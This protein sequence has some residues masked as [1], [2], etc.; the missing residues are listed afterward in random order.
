[1]RSLW[2]AAGGGG[3]LCFVKFSEAVEIHIWIDAFAGEKV[4]I[5]CIWKIFFQNFEVA[6]LEI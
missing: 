1:M 6:G 2:K 4:E 5:Y 3:K